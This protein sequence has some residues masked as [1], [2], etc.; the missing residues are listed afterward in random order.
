MRLQ[1]KHNIKGFQL[2]LKSVKH[3]IS[4]SRELQ[5][6]VAACE[7]QRSRNCSRVV[8]DMPGRI[9]S[10]NNN[11]TRDFMSV[12]IMNWTDA[13]C[14]EVSDCTA[15]EKIPFAVRHQLLAVNNSRQMLRQS[16]AHVVYITLAI[17]FTAAAVVAAAADCSAQSAR[18]WSHRWSLDFSCGCTTLRSVISFSV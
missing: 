11:I 12:M 1:C 4:G 7:K 15:I 13:A 18:S 16:M 17:N 6:L 3:Y 2:A 9:R 14:T 8:S 10:C 5:A